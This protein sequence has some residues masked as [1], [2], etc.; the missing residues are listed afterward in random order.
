M[1]NNKV[2]YVLGQKQTRQHHCHWPGCDKQVPPAKW[3]C[4]PHWRKL[5]K[6]LRDKIWATFEPGQEIK[7]TPS[8]EYV[9]VAKEIQEWIMSN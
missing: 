2:Q 6:H 1:T 7:M 8:R 3:G 5:P 4:L 9:K